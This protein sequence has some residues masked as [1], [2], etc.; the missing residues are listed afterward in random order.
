ML[1][2]V[3]AP[4][5]KPTKRPRYIVTR[6]ILTY[7]CQNLACLVIIFVYIHD[8]FFCCSDSSSEYK[9][10]RQWYLVAST[11]SA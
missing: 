7:F 1:C 4:H 3:S 10:W 2:K 11:R 5:D 6:M 8:V 9:P